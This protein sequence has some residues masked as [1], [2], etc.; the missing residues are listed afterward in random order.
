MGENNQIGQFTSLSTPHRPNL[1]TPTQ[2]ASP[3]IKQNVAAAYDITESASL[4]NGAAASLA[5]Q[6]LRDRAKA[7][8]EAA[9]EQKAQEV[10]EKNDRN[11]INPAEFSRVTKSRIHENLARVKEMGSLDDVQVERQRVARIVEV[12]KEASKK[13]REQVHNSLPPKNQ[14]T[15]KELQLER[16]QQFENYVAEFNVMAEKVRV[17]YYDQEVLPF[18]TTA[19]AIPVTPTAPSAPTAP[20]KPAQASQA[21]QASQ[22][23]QTPQAPRAPAVSPN[24][25]AFVREAVAAPA[26]VKS[27]APAVAQPTPPSQQAGMQHRR[28]GVLNTTS[29]VRPVSTLPTID[30][31]RLR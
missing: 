13:E 10:A 16:K 25:S 24:R 23:L 8:R 18:P 19:Q 5:L 15:E 27:Q 30:A 9:K 14:K 11:D 17:Q 3:R 22:T 12:T 2:A 21:L 31:G 4:A 28:G 1:L 7:T 26:N 20:A 29:P 6:R